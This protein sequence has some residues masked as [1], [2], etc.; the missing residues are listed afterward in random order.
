[1]NSSTPRRLDI[2]AAVGLAI[3]GVF[4][5]A[6]TLAGDAALRQSFWA[7]DGVGL[8]VA[9]TLLAVRFL[10]SGD[11]CVAAGFLVFA[12]GEGLLVSGN[13]AGLERSVPSFGG[14]VALWAAGLLLISIPAALA[15]WVRWAGMA[16]AVPFAVVAARIS[17][18]EVLLPTTAP[19]PFFGYP[20]LV[21]TFIGWIAALLKRA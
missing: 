17:S 19:L 1:V 2:V 16:A 20:L 5:L 7:I 15:T 8:V 9:T 6:G 12:I 4:G 3:G 21:L 18:G 14:G 11:D 10:R 13:A